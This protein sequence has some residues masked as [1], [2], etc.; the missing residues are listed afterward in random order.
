[1]L[2]LL[3]YD[4]TVIRESYE[5]SGHDEPEIIYTCDNFPKCPISIVN[6]YSCKSSLAAPRIGSPERLLTVKVKVFFKIWEEILKEDQ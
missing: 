1:M 3:P 5:A 4:S 6:A 2:E